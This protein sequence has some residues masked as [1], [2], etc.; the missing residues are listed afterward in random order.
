[1]FEDSDWKPLCQ[2]FSDEECVRYTIQ[3]IL[4]D[5]QT[6]RTLA[7]Y[8]GHWKL[9]G[10]GP[11]AVVERATG[12]MLGP[13]GLWYPAEWPEP[14]VKWALVR[15]AW[16]KGYATE[17]ASA[18]IDMAKQH[19]GWTRLISLIFPQNERSKNVAARLGGIYEET[20]PFRDAVAEIFAYD[21]T[22]I[23]TRPL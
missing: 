20:I 17:A 2:L 14:E 6:W 21:L 19:L 1:M 5:W 10:F 11:Y 15:T 3:T 4:P 13:V 7:A 16:G 12:T 9:R 18:V 22:R 8:V 23:E